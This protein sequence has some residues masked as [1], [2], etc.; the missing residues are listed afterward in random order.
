MTT[1]LF[2]RSLGWETFELNHGVFH[3]LFPA[4]LNLPNIKNFYWADEGLGA[5]FSRISDQAADCFERLEVIDLCIANHKPCHVSKEQVGRLSDC[6]RQARNLRELTLCF[7][8]SK[9]NIMGVELGDHEDPGHPLIP[10][11]FDH[12]HC[13]PKLHHLK[14]VDV[15][16]PHDKLT[17]FVIRHAST[18]RH[19]KL[20]QC[21]VRPA[22]FH[23]IAQAREVHLDSIELLPETQRVIVIREEDLLDYI[24]GVTKD[25]PFSMSEG[26]SDISTATW[27]TLWDYRQGWRT[28]AYFDASMALYHDRYDVEAR[29]SLFGIKEPPPEALSYRGGEDQIGPGEPELGPDAN[30]Y[31]SSADISWPHIKFSTIP[32]TATT[33]SLG[34]HG[35]A[36]PGKD[37]RNTVGDD[38]D[39]DMDMEDAASVA[40]IDSDV[41]R[42]QKAPR[43]A[44]GLYETDMWY[45]K[46]PHNV[47]DKTGQPAGWPTKLWY[48]KYR[49]GCVAY[50]DD[51]LEFFSDWDSEAGDVSEPTPYGTPL[52]G[53]RKEEQDILV[54]GW[55][56]LEGSEPPEGALPY[57]ARKDPTHSENPFQF[58]T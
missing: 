45:W 31:I 26:W 49:N 3:I 36:Q 7:E 22:V 54:P 24:N 47:A 42:R 46:E 11:L 25:S 50:G 51:P 43:W 57:D 12:G 35:E 58:S 5:S 34:E 27:G 4:M 8:N 44:F 19:L 14:L 23:K 41:R 6:L 53:F 21:S 18:L 10:L 29:E 40:S 2:R 48:F 55:E 30:S 13:W 20:H 9:H 16:V 39:V 37:D 33:G 56:T 52:S 15:K 32:P 17:D 1:Q 38:V 28:A